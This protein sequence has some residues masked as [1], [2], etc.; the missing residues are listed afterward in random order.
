MQKYQLV[1]DAKRCLSKFI[2]FYNFRRLHQNLTY[3]TPD[4]VYNNVEKGSRFVYA[5]LSKQSR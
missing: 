1:T 3:Q 2:E 4:E 5:K